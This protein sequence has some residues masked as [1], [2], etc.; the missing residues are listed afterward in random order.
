MKISLKEG[1]LF[2]RMV[3]FTLLSSLLN[4]TDRRIIMCTIMMRMM[5]VKNE[6]MLASLTPI[7]LTVLDKIDKV[8][9][10]SPFSKF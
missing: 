7:V 5:P 2:S 8:F 1:R 9:F 3:Q 10:L 4:L 6:I